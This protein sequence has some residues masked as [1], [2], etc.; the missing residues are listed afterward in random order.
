MLKEIQ[1]KIATIIGDIWVSSG[2]I[3]IWPW[4]L[5]AYGPYRTQIKGNDYRI[6][7]A[8]LKPG[9]MILTTQ[10]KYKGSN[11][12]I[13]GTFKHLMVYTGTVFGQYDGK[14]ISIPVSYGVDHVFNLDEYFPSKFSRTITH[15]ESEGVSTQDLLDV[16][17]HYDEMVVVRPWKTKEQ[18][19]AIVKKA[20]EQNGKEYD[21]VF[22]S[23]SDESLYCTELGVVCLKAAGIEVPETIMKMTKVWKPWK[24]SRVY[25]ADFFVEKYDLVCKTMSCNNP[26]FYKGPLA[27]VLKSKLGTCIDANKSSRECTCPSSNG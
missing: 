24:R 8:L 18:Q 5:V 7:T 3:G 17:S 10:N 22:D 6:F 21:F 26:Y 2:I 9:D 14:S 23:D 27:N 20:L 11:S 19:E 25:V 15:A 16:F 12:A 1:A 4:P 13:P